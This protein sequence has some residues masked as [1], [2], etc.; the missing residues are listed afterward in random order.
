[1]IN[2]NLHSVLMN[3]T[4]QSLISIRTFLAIQQCVKHSV[5][6]LNSMT[7][8]KEQTWWSHLIFLDN[9]LKFLTTRNLKQQMSYHIP[10]NIFLHFLNDPEIMSFLAHLNQRLTGELI[11]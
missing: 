1:M 10:L 2:G 11:E 4:T 7:I 3:Y 6:D 8:P 9:V 5:F